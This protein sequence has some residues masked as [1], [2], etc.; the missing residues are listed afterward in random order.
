MPRLKIS[1]KE[2]KRR[3]LDAAIRAG[4]AREGIRSAEELGARIGI[5]R[6]PMNRRMS[7]KT[8]WKF[9]EICDISRV[10]HFSDAEK[11]RIL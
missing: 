9:E 3:E 6:D 5:K 4:M 2:R 10:L 8:A 7:R 11:A 1:E